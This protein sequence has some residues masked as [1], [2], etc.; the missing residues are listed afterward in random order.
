MTAR[1]ARLSFTRGA[2]GASGRPDCRRESRA[3]R[4]RRFNPRLMG[5]ARGLSAAMTA[6]VP[7]RRRQWTTAAAMQ[8]LR[9]FAA[10]LG[11]RPGKA[12]FVAHD[13]L[14]LYFALK[15]HGDRRALLDGLP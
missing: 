2:E 10:Q 4:P 14:P 8:E 7:R 15:N 5:R 6:N 3:P 1:G 11:Y 9:E 13:R 12:D